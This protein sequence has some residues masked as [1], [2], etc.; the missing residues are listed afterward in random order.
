MPSHS[1][2]VIT[3]PTKSPMKDSNKNSGSRRASFSET[4]ILDQGTSLLGATTPMI[5][6]ETPRSV[7]MSVL[8]SSFFCVYLIF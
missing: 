2:S 5:P 3:T 8:Y 4:F 1:A 7:S 6:A